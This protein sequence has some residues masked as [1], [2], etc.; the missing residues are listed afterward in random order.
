MIPPTENKKQPYTEKAIFPKTREKLEVAIHFHA[1][2]PQLNGLNCIFNALKCSRH[3]PNLNIISRF[4]FVHSIY[5]VLSGT[6][7]AVDF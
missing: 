5:I 6:R 7:W 1:E 3:L 4:S 2:H